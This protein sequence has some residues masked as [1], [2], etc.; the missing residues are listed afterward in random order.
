MTVTT[1]ARRLVA[2]LGFAL[3]AGLGFAVAVHTPA[4]RAD[5]LPLPV[6]VPSLPPLPPPLPPLP[7]TD[8]VTV[9]ATTVTVP[10]G[11]SNPSSSGAAAEQRAVETLDDR[12][13][14][15]PVN[16][17]KPTGVARVA[18]ARRLSNGLISIPVSSVVLPARLVIERVRFSPAR[19]TPSSATLKASVRIRDTR[20]YVVRGARLEIRYDGAAK[21]RLG[22]VRTSALDG[23]VGSTMDIRTLPPARSSRLPLLIRAYKVDG[24][25]VGGVAAQRRVAIPIESRR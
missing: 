5:G 18:G 7:T 22:P 13:N 10:A 11:S 6:P 19:L 14:A 4:A 3:A 23:G 17:T 9:P 1:A 15:A 20:G 24:H 21:S 8:T 2:S 12:S 16:S 25:P